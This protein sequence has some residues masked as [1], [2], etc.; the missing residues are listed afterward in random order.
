MNTS[1]NTDE[2]DMTYDQ[3]IA[4]YSES[5]SDAVFVLDSGEVR[6]NV[7]NLPLVELPPSNGD[8]LILESMFAFIV[9]IYNTHIVGLH[10]PATSSSADVDTP[11]SGHYQLPRITPPVREFNPHHH[12]YNTYL[13]A[14]YEE[15]GLTTEEPRSVTSTEDR[16]A[17]RYAPYPAH[18]RENSDGDSERDSSD[19][20]S[21]DSE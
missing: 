7:E 17:D 21:A 3:I 15:Y 12:L 20:E 16:R 1:A 11:T 14:Y 6:V 19:S 9:A 4:W 18:Y 13:E 8:N 5:F 2:L 10:A